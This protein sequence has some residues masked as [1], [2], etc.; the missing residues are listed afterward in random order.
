MSK[1]YSRS[2]GGFYTKDIHAEHQI[3]AD[4][5][6]ITD[7]YWRE[8]LDAQARGQQIVCGTHG[9]PIAVD[10]DPA[11][12]LLMSRDIALRETDWLVARH[13][14][15]VELDPNQ[16]T[17]TTEQYQALQSWRRTLRNLSSMPGFPRITLPERPV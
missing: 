13:R 15:E 16:T 7:E 3:P 11:P 9:E 10:R 17:L 5:V 12:G 14:D 6:E 4:V 8:L 1:F 2:T